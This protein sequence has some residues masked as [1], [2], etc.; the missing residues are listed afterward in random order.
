MNCQWT[1]HTAFGVAAIVV[2]L[3]GTTFAADPAMIDLKCGSQTVA[4]YM[5]VANPMKPYV[6][7]LFSPSGVQL[8]LDSPPDHV[9]HHGLMF[10][11]GAGD[12]EYFGKKPARGTPAG[13]LGRQIP[14]PKGTKT[15]SSSIEQAIDWTQ[16]DGTRQL[17]ERRTVRVH[18]RTAGGPNVLTWETQL[19]AVEG[20]GPVKL[21]GRHYFG[22]GLRPVADLNETARFSVPAGAPPAHKVVFGELRESAA[23]CAFTG[24]VGG[25]PI[26]V[27]IWDDPRNRPRAIWYSMVKP[28]TYLGATIGLPDR[29]HRDAKQKTIKLGPMEN[30]LTLEPGKSLTLRY[31]VAVFDGNVGAEA[32]D[33]ARTAWLSVETI[34]QSSV[35]PAAKPFQLPM[36]PGTPWHMHDERRPQPAVVTPGARPGDPPSDAIVLF[37]GKDLSEWQEVGF[38]NIFRVMDN[39]GR[40][41]GNPAKWKVVDGVL[42]CV[43]T[44]GYIGTKLKFGDVQLHLEFASPNP[45]GGDD[46]MGGNSGVF[47]GD[48]RYEIQILDSFTNRCCADGQCGAVY[49]QFPPLVSVNRKPGEWQSFDI[50]FHMPTFENDKLLT[51][52]IATVFQNGVLLHDHRALLG[53]T[54]ALSIE[55]YKPHGKC[56]L[57]L[58]EHGSPVRFRNIWVRE[59]DKDRAINK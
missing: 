52:A 9:H 28:M 46:K 19:E 59:L 40:L 23:W 6:K 13:D 8:L 42:E 38:T 26:T 56:S 1:L 53:G 39:P 11:V 50:I 44:A 37:D 22:L 10:A 18:P 21:W 20:V 2:L 32:I 25:K 35:K 4:R 49:G 3:S 48:G 15:D 31:G 30:P 24:Q 47:F 58:Q 12:T 7:E 57:M 41:T 27:A 55:R 43:P 51:P 16:A 14:N 54:G 33:Q 5:P 45:P 34:E 17:F 29:V 36:I